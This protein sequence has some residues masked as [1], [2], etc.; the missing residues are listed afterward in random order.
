MNTKHRSNTEF[1]NP[2]LKISP[3]TDKK[4]IVL[5]IKLLQFFILFERKW[6]YF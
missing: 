1:P 4:K 3:V 5:E 2:V 6:V